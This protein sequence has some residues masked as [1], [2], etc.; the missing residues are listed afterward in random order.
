[1][2]PLCD[3]VF[4][5][6]RQ[7]CDDFRARYPGA[8]IDVLSNATSDSFCRI[9]DTC[10]IPE[11]LR[12]IRTLGS[13][14]VGCVGQI[15]SSYDWTLLEAAASANPRA[16]FVF[17]G[18]LFE[19]GEPTQR[20]RKFFMGSN[21]HWLGAK[22]HE[23]L[24]SY[25]DCCDI[26]LN[27]LTVNGQ[28]DRRDTL[29]LYDYLTAQATVVSTSIDGAMRHGDLVRIPSSE[30]EMIAV[31]GRIPPPLN[32]DEITKRRAYIA[33]NTWSARGRQLATALE[34]ISR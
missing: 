30:R 15:N 10:A 4:T 32:S 13:P 23:E 16:Q 34:Q 14:L 7:L 6:S 5:I 25:M 19:E 33:E 18:N 12:R 27:P 21:V 26:L 11:D 22:P 3:R 20:I 9:A 28:N 1:M 29:R 2:V 24:K 8:E 31:L 17:I